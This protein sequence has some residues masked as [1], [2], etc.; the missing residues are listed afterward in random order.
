MSRALKDRMARRLML[1]T[2]WVSAGELA[3]GLST[4]QVAI[5][6]ALAD[7][8]V[9]GHAQTNGESPLMGYRFNASALCREAARQLMRGKSVRQ[10]VGK[11]FESVYRLGVAEHRRGLGVVTYDLE[12]P[13]PADLNDYPKLLNAIANGDMHV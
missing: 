7:L 11:P 1:A 10:V 6:D 13:L 8:V 9:E 5:D 4:C 12:L 2:R 3:D